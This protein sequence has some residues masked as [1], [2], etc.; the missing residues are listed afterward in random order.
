[1]K[2]SAALFLL[3]SIDEA[4]HVDAKNPK[5]I[6]QRNKYQ[7]SQQGQRRTKG[8]EGKGKGYS[9]DETIAPTDRAT[10]EPI[11]DD[12]EISNDGSHLGLICEI[13]QSYNDLVLAGSNDLDFCLPFEMESSLL[14]PNAYEIGK[15]CDGVQIELGLNVS[16]VDNY[17][18][19]L[20]D[21]MY[22]DLSMKE[23]CVDFCAAF[24]NEGDCCALTCN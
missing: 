21:D 23:N 16:V 6:R 17:C 19:L 1:M 4:T 2:L 18:V 15:I 5:R 3:L 12:A 10:G 9:G 20:F 22:T 13:L 14:C 7:G 8:D 11:E 24:V